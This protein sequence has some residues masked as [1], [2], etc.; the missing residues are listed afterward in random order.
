MKSNKEAKTGLQTPSPKGTGEP[1]LNSIQPLCSP[2]IPVYTDNMNNMNNNVFG[3]P[4]GP[5]GTQLYQQNSQQMLPGQMAYNSMG[6][7]VGPSTSPGSC[8]PMLAPPYMGNMIPPSQPASSMYNGPPTPMSTSASFPT[9]ISPQSSHSEL[10]QLLNSKFDEVYKR[11][12]KLDVVEKKVN[13]IDV[14]VSKLWSDLDKRVAKNAN[15]ITAVDNKTRPTDI[16][17]EN[18]KKDLAALQKQNDGLKETLS[19]IQSNSMMNNLIIGGIEQVE[20]ETTE[21]TENAVRNFL[22]ND[23]QVPPE[24]LVDI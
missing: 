12:D 19:D 23:L 7:G 17:L 21:Q 4:V 2:P 22:A 10:A 9:S 3:S 20:N 5:V 16:E 11:L 24:R 18:T 13:D 6:M 8:R 1:L 15:D 14:K